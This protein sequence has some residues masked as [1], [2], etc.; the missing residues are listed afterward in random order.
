MVSWG[1][2]KA[3][4]WI[5]FAYCCCY[6]IRKNYPLLL[7]HLEAENLLSTD[8]AAL[9]ASI[10]EVVVGLIKLFC[11]VYVD[12]HANPALLLAQCL[13]VAGGACVLMQAVF[14]FLQGQSFAWVRVFLVSV[15]WSINGAGQ[16]VAWPALARVFMNWFPDAASRGFWYGVL[17]TNQNLG[18]TLAPR[19]YPPLIEAYGWEIALFAPA[20]VT[21]AYGF[22]M[23]LSLT[24][25]PPN[26]NG[27]DSDSTAHPTILVDNGEQTPQRHRRAKRGM[28]RA[29]VSVSD[30]LSNVAPTPAKNSAR[31]AL[32]AELD[33]ENMNLL[34][35]AAHLFRLPS[36]LCL[37]F[38]YIPVMVIRMG[39]GIWT[40]V[41]FKDVGLTAF[42]AG[43]CIAAL[44]IGGAVGGM[45]GGR[46]SDRLLGGRRGPV[47]CIFSL[48]CTPLGLV[49]S[50]LLETDGDV[51]Y[52]MDRLLL[53]QLIYFLI[54]VFSFPPH[55]FI[56]LMSRELVPE[57]M[58]ST[59]GCIAKAVGQIGAAAAGWPL[60]QVAVVYGWS[61]IGYA[62]AA[63]GV[64]AALIFSPLWFVHARSSQSGGGGGAGVKNA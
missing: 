63:C 56:G 28:V 52:G 26:G 19:L 36:F 7:P 38:A 12:S 10:F 47:M 50:V 61:C 24:S 44:E 33:T 21:V 18:G 23:S 51:A 14:S 58:R 62:S 3:L 37:C 8:Q 13:F 34:Q 43:K 25:R 64:A 22:A 6:L 29:P 11:G 40:A 31:A 32:E 42:D 1:Q 5:Y 45:I 55:S 27:G 2:K 9:V 46:V 48:M 59:A 53:L 57:K 20:L 60:Q 17:A 15:L 49:L 16:A 39:V 35:M 4:G 54:G 41:M 30:V